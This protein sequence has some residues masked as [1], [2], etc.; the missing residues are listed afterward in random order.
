[1]TTIC[2]S[3]PAPI[4]A[5][6]KLISVD[7]TDPPAGSACAKRRLD[8]GLWWQDALLLCVRPIGDGY[9][10]WRSGLE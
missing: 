5:V 1:M 3:A 9:P 4:T 10:S 7:L 2:R 8:Q 6:A